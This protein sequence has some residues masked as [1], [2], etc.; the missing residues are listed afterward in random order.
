MGNKYKECAEC[1]ECVFNMKCPCGYFCN[2]AACL[3]LRKEYAEA[4]TAKSNALYERN[5]KHS[6]T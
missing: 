1:A 4:M 3:T 5:E 6:V 2:N